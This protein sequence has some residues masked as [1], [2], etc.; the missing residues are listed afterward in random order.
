MSG[1]KREDIQITT[2]V[3]Y[4]PPNSKDKIYPWNANNI[5][6]GETQSLDMSLKQLG[7]DY[8]DLLLIHTPFTGPEE[9]RSAFTPHFFEW[10]HE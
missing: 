10:G 3:G 6:G 1:L 7:T 4:F 9:F 8:V 2:K 5:K